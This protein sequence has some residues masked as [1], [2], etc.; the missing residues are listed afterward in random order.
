MTP[1]EAKILVV[2]DSLAAR[3]LMTAILRENGYK[4]I[5]C[6]PTGEEAI[7]L[8]FQRQ[9]ETGLIFDL[10]LMDI[11]MP[12][13][14]NGIEAVKQIRTNFTLTG[15]L[16]IMVTVVDEKEQLCEAFSAGAID[17]ITKPVNKLEL[18]ARIGSVLRLKCEMDERKRRQDD[19]LDLVCEVNNAYKKLEDL[20]QSLEQK[21]KERTS[22]LEKAYSELQQLDKMKDAFISNISHE[23]RTPLTSIVGYGSM[24]KA[25]LQERIFP[26]IPPNQVALE[27]SKIN[28]SI[29]IILTEANWLTEHI[30]AILEITQ[31]ETN[32][33]LWDHQKVVLS[34]VVR[35]VVERMRPQFEEKALTLTAQIPQH[36]PEIIGDP[37][38]LRRLT[39]YLL[40]NALKFTEKGSVECTLTLKD[41]NFFLIVADTGIGI[42]KEHYE[43]VFDKFRQCGDKVTGKPQGTGLGLP[44]S[45]KIVQHHK[46]EIWLQSEVGKGT[47]FFCKLPLNNELVVT[48]IN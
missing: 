23:F 14:M 41:G 32:E 9:N 30:G 16:V 22:E 4:N 28:N 44:L 45:R 13:G 25:R 38:R 5:E 42:A 7:S 34:N 18:L 33:L 43:A 47:S 35:D 39:K 17:Y 24:L 11:N 48:P 37:T 40:S 26:H 46:G 6:T 19:Y 2:D 15:T 12:G 31:M 10:I 8:I 3:D 20:N 29:D 1:Q 21:V 36:V 27:A